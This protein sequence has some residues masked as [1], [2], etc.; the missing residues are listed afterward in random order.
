MA[1]HDKDSGDLSSAQLSI[2][3]VDLVLENL[4]IA[5]LAV[6]RFPLEKAY[7]LR[8]GLRQQGLFNLVEVSTWRR[9]KIYDALLASSY[10]RGSFLVGLI[11]DRV[12]ALSRFVAGPEWSPLLTDFEAG[13]KGRVGKRLLGVSGIGPAVVENFWMLSS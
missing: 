11:S 13:F 2:S 6:N 3:G 10:N 12:A 8:E 1:Q 7:G 9:E 4:V 5:L